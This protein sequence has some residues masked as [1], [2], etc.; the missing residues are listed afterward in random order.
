[1]LN[2]VK[3][4]TLSA[5]AGVTLM[6]GC[7]TQVKAPSTPINPAPSEAFSKFS[8][9]ELK[10]I[11]TNE[12]CDKQHGADQ[13]LSLIQE[14]LNLKLGSMVSNWN[15]NKAGGQ[16]SRK[17]VIEPVCSDAKLVGGAARFWGG[18]FAGSSAV[19]MKVRYTDAAS[20]RVIAEPVFYQRANAM[21]AAWTFGAT[22]RNMLD[23]IV[24][25]ISDYTAKNYQNAVGGSTGL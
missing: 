5:I 3:L 12:S 17:L 15:A 25:L 1:M 10:P 7:A 13:A 11:N 2:N 16:P 20:G 24:D 21:G 19:V 8:S 14:K 4:A 22:D 23:R 9:F 18:A 6:A